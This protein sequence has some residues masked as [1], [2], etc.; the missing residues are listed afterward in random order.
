VDARFSFLILDF[1][2]AK[3]YFTAKSAKDAK[4]AEKE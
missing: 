3:N 2:K 1:K 4:K